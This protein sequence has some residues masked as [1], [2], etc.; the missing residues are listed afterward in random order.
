MW[1][2]LLGLFIVS[3][4]V[5][6]AGGYFVSTNKEIRSQIEQVI[7][8][9]KP[10]EVRVGAASI[11][12][13][14][15]TISAPGQIEAL[16]N[17]QIS[18]Q[19]SARIIALPFQLNGA[20]K[21][22]DVIVR[23]DAREF[24]AIRE[25]ARAQ[26]K[27]EQAR[28]EGAQAALTRAQLDRERVQRLASSGD[29]TPADVERAESDFLSAQSTLLAAQA[30]IDAA[31]AQILRTE[32]DLENTIITSPIDGVITRLD[33]EVGEVVV[34]GTLNNPGSVIMEIADLSQMILKARVDESNIVPVDEGQAARVYINAYG[35]R[36][37]TGRVSRVELQRKVDRDNTGYFEVEIPLDPTPGE[38][39][40][41]GLT[42]NTDIAVET[43]RDVLVVPSQAVVDRKVD[44]L[45]S[46]VTKDNPNI[47]KNNTFARV[48]FRLEPAGDKTSRD[49]RPMLKAIA[50]PVQA[51]SSDLTRTV[52]IAGLKAGD[53]IVT[54]PF[55]VLQTLQH[56]AEVVEE[57][58]AATKKD[59]AK[60]EDSGKPQE[61]ATPESESAGSTKGPA[62]GR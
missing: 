56:D 46:A 48:V 7:P 57:G 44:E 55:K 32:K 45:P 21:K 19:V 39:L 51:G 28:L 15:R 40:R 38:T 62:A 30:A 8:R 4:V 50:T 2:W 24:E 47:P 5:C 37:F 61:P 54:G 9:P 41:A 60:S 59:Q 43:L 36:E 49:G 20:V 1:K 3:V 18:A 34:I 6:A 33:A 31:R 42:A 22:G 25:S 53:R 13:L 26:L 16:T 14:S 35:E 17:V 27:G 58:A 52:I 11:G 29:R 23:L 10:T 12:E